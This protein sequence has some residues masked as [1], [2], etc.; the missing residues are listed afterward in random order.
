MNNKIYIVKRPSG[1]YEDYQEPI[2]KCFFDKDNANKY[3]ESEN[4][5]LPLEQAEKCKFCRFWAN[6]PTIKGKGKP[7]CCDWDK[8]NTCQ[9][10]FKYHDIYPLEIEEHD[11]EDL[12]D[13]DK[14]LV[15]R[16][17]KEVE[18]TFTQYLPLRN[19]T[20]AWFYGRLNEILGRYQKEFEDE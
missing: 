13:H 20:G 14:E 18:D 16:V 19:R 4:K 5:K 6:N 8:Y 15:A 10:Y 9:N 3:I 11:I 1:S 7:E 2:E 17:L 12:H